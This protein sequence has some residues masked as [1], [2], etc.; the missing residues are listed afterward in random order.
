[1]LDANLISLQRELKST[2]ITTKS[3][4]GY[5]AKQKFLSEKNFHFFPVYTKGN[6][7]PSSIFLYFSG[8]VCEE[9][10]TVTLQEIDCDIISVKQMAAEVPLH[11]EESL[12]HT[13]P[14]PSF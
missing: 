13:P 7:P 12:T 2:W 1:M 9:D 8:N 6:K 4:V 3:M 14:F 5:N 10:I 11:E